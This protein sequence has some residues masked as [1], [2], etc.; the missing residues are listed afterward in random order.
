MTSELSQSILFQALQAYQY[1]GARPK[2][3]PKKF[4]FFL[5]RAWFDCESSP[6]FLF[7]NEQLIPKNLE[8]ITQLF[9][10]DGPGTALARPYVSLFETTPTEIDQESRQLLTQL[11]W[12]STRRDALILWQHNLQAMLPQN[13]KLKF[14]YYFDRHV[15]DDFQ[16]LVLAYF[17]WS[18]PD[19]RRFE[20]SDRDILKRTHCVVITNRRNQAIATG[21]VHVSNGVAML[22]WGCVAPRHRGRKLWNVLVSVRQALCAPHT[23]TMLTTQNKTLF[24][25]GDHRFIYQTFMP[26][27]LQQL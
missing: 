23:L 1:S 9:N 18:Q 7:P 27:T 11:G 10:S 12:Q 26:A 15:H 8:L 22:Q 2:N 24:S 6:L 4:S 17:K 14:G 16:Q 5:D 3:F 13:Y 25:R 21:T 20:R 19:L